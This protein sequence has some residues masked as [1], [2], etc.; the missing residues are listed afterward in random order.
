MSNAEMQGARILRFH[1]SDKVFHS[2][3]NISFSDSIDRKSVV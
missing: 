3:S 2:L 1:T